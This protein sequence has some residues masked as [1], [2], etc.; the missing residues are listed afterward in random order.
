MHST[1]AISFGSESTNLKKLDAAYTRHHDF[2]KINEESSKAT[3]TENGHVIVSIQ[4]LK[5]CT[6]SFDSK[7][8]KHH[9]LQS[10]TVLAEVSYYWQQ[11]FNRK[12]IKGCNNYCKY[13]WYHY[14][15]V[16][17]RKHPLT[18]RFCPSCRTSP[19]TKRV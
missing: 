17:L 16:S 9:H 6:I 4:R 10:L 12:M 3:L 5:P 13:A 15:C 14:D 11:T 2:I 1:T 8:K 18:T 19:T 7:S